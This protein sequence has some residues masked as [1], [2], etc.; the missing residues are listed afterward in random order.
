MRLA[1]AACLAGVGCAV[2]WFAPFIYFG[3][4]EV[5]GNLRLSREAVLSRAGLGPGGWVR[6]ATLRRAADRLALDPR[7]REAHLRWIP[8]GTVQVRVRERLAV[9][10]VPQEGGWS[11]LDESGRLIPAGPDPDELRR[12]PV[13]FTGERLD[14]DRLS[15]GLEALAQIQEQP[16][17][18]L[19]LGREARRSIDL[20][21][22]GETILRVGGYRFLLPERW[23][24]DRWRRALALD[25]GELIPSG[26]KEMSV[27]LR[28]PD[29]VVVEAGRK[30][31]VER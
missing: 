8:P 26:N 25:Q 17:P 31:V 7:I 15:A 2:V 5:E 21:H 3:S 1:A 27:D 12:L 23:D 29:R 18:G 30:E 22:S 13:V 16:P 19:N 20:R 10:I 28:F 6:L 14:A 11:L 9:A 24:P 4:A